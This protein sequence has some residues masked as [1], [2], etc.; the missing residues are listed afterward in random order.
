MVKYKIANKVENNIV[1]LKMNMFIMGFTG[2]VGF[3]ITVLLDGW[4]RKAEPAGIQT[5][6]EKDQGLAGRNFLVLT[7]RTHVLQGFGLFI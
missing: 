1:H 5:P 4:D 2:C 6:V 3:S 7:T